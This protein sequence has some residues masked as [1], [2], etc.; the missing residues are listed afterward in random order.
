M[1]DQSDAG[2]VGCAQHPRD[3]FAGNIPVAGT[4]RA[5]EEGIYPS[6]API[7]SPGDPSTDVTRL[8]LHRDCTKI[9][10]GVL[11]EPSPLLAQE[12]P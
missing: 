7:A 11:S 12:D 6:R 9:Q 8:L 1:T 10:A 3:P 4:N 5:R 2:S